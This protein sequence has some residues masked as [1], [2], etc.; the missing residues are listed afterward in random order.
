[1]Y[2][3]P[4][5]LT[6]LFRALRSSTMRMILITL[7][8]FLSFSLQAKPSSKP[9][10]VVIFMDDMAYADIGPFG[11][12]GYETPNLNRMAKELSLIHI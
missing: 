5:A 9:N 10:I 11:A 4:G 8:G 7:I 1:M 2:L 3:G 12:K 6:R